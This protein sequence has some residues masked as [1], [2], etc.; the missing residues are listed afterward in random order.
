MFFSC[1]LVIIM[2]KVVNAND[3]FLFRVQYRSLTL[4]AMLWSLERV[5][6]SRSVERV[7]EM[8]WDNWVC[9]KMWA[10]QRGQSNGSWRRN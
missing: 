3:A 1:P 10:C 8:N 2:V 7:Y 5:R 9:H 4:P 6:E